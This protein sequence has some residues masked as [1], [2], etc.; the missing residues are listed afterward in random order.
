MM[1]S[2]ARARKVIVFLDY[3]WCRPYRLSTK[4]SEYNK[5]RLND[6]AVFDADYTIVPIDGF[7]PTVLEITEAV[8]F[9]NNEESLRDGE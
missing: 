7:H 3:T 6:P 8:E 2:S 1:K 5:D 9:M 4:L